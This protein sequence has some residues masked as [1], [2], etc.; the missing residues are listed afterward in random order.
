M[1]SFFNT[2]LIKIEETS[3]TNDFA[4]ELLKK[5]KIKE[6]AV[7]FSQF[8]KKGKGQR[9]AKWE[10]EYGKN[11]LMSIVLSP[12]IL[13]VNQFQLNV[14][15]SLALHDFSKK[16]FLEKTKNTSGYNTHSGKNISKPTDGSEVSTNRASV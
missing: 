14:C 7:I 11:I 15:I 6:G 2:K 4:Y 3:S 9:G 10:S 13:V 8:Q 5:G 16:Y 12:D 1:A